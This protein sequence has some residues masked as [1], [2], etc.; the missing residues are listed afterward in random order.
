[1]LQTSQKDWLEEP[2]GYHGFKLADGSM[3]P[4][5]GTLSSKAWL[6]GDEMVQMTM[7]VANIAQPLLS[8]GQLVSKGNKVVLSPKVSYV[9]TKTGRT[10]R[11]FLRNG[12]YVLPLWMESS[13]TAGGSYPFE[14]QGLESP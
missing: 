8:V 9:E 4:N 13:K 6:L 7:S 3:V 12:V 5:E 11:I 2:V 10:H 1:M 14:G